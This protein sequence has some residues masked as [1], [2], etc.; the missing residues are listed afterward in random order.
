M[1]GILLDMIDFSELSNIG[2]SEWTFLLFMLFVEDARQK[3]EEWLHFEH[4]LIYKNRF[5]SNSPI[6]EELHKREGQ[7]TI[8]LPSGKE[9]YRARSFK[10]SSFDKLIEYYIKEYG[11]TKEEIDTVLR[12]RSATLKKWKQPLG[13]ADNRCVAARNQTDEKETAVSW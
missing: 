8:I 10:K 13:R 6:V 3:N 1:K 9:L 11:C 7:A 12:L 2:N 4:D 5:S